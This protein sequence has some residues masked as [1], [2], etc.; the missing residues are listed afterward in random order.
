[1]NLTAAFDISLREIFAHKFRSFLSMLGIVLGVASLIGTLALTA[2]MEHGT[3]KTLE[4]IGGLERVQI[5]H[6]DLSTG[7]IDF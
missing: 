1:M 5:N 4:Q 7:D 6:V 2:G 3:R